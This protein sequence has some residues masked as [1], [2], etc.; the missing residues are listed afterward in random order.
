VKNAGW[1]ETPEQ[2][3]AANVATCCSRRCM[4]KSACPNVPVA[5]ESNGSVLSAS[6]FQQCKY[7]NPHLSLRNLNLLQQ[8]S[9]EPEANR[10]SKVK[11]DRLQGDQGPRGEPGPKGEFCK[12]PNGQADINLM[13]DVEK[14]ENALKEL[15]QA[16][17][18]RRKRK[19]LGEGD[20]SPSS[21]PNRNQ[22]R[23]RFSIE[24]NRRI[25]A[26]HKY[27]KMQKRSKK[28]KIYNRKLKQR[29]TKKKL[30]HQLEH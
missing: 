4:I 20:Q 21:P 10:E 2:Y 18:V 26:E 8:R 28:M 9:P 27:K 30:Q 24:R 29:L 13:S 17:R 7:L 1:I 3:E 6:L 14:Y 25:C 16:G 5:N 15:K 11:R 19:W 22:V 23:D 12:C